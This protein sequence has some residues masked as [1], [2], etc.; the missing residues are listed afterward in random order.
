[1]KKFTLVVP[2]KE[3]RDSLASYFESKN[4]PFEKHFIYDG[5][6]QVAEKSIITISSKDASIFLLKLN[7]MEA[8]ELDFYESVKKYSTKG[9]EEV[10]E[11]ILAKVVK[12]SKTKK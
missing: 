5:E 10:K 6:V 9:S 3:H 4:M 11:L 12:K 1:M 2:S 7:E 8:K